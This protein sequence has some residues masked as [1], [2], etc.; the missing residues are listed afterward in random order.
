MYIVLDTVQIYVILVISFLIRVNSTYI[1]REVHCKS[2]IQF[3]FSYMVRYHETRLTLATTRF[4]TAHRSLRTYFLVKVDTIIKSHDAIFLKNLFTMK[5]FSSN[6]RFHFEIVP[7]FTTSLQLS[8]TNNH[9]RNSFRE[10]TIRTRCLG[11][12]IFNSNKVE[13]DV[14]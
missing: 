2:F 12:S 10:T 9:K 4:H 11:S 1:A 14:E 6:S 8:L 7:E 13:D 3:Y 5:D